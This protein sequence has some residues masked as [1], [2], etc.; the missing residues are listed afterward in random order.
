MVSIGFDRCSSY[1]RLRRLP[2]SVAAS[3]RQGG[4]GLAA[5]LSQVRGLPVEATQKKKKIYYSFYTDLGKL[6]DLFPVPN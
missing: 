3:S 2:L 6:V 4:L 5:E 1:S